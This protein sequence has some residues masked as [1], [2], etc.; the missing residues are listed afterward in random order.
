MGVVRML[1]ALVKD[2]YI[3]WQCVGTP[4]VF[5][6]LPVYVYVYRCQRTALT[7]WVYTHTA[8]YVLNRAVCG[9]IGAIIVNVY[10]AIANCV[11]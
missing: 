8:D 1:P 7:V 11:V 10:T 2:I 3:I 4:A 6:D 9:Y 5:C